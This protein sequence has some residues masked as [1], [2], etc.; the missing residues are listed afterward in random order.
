MINFLHVVCDTAKVRFFKQI[1]TACSIVLAL[2]QL[3]AIL[4]KYDFSSK[5]QQA[6]GQIIEGISCLRYCKSTI[7]Q[8]NHNHDPRE[9]LKKQLF[10]ILQKYDF[11]SK[12]QLTI[13]FAFLLL[14]CLRYCK[15]TIFQANH[16]HYEVIEQDGNVVCDTAKVR[17]FKQITTYLVMW[18]YGHQLFAIL[19]KYDFSSKSQPRSS[20]SAL[21]TVVCDTA[22]VRFFKQITTSTIGLCIGSMLFAILQKYDFSSKSQ[23]RSRRTSILL[24]CLR[25]CKSTIFQANHNAS[26]KDLVLFLVVCDTAKVR[27]FKQITTEVGIFE[28][29]CELFAILQKYDFSSK[30]QQT[31]AD[32]AD[33]SV[34]CDTAKVRFFKQITTNGEPLS[35]WSMLFAIL[36]KYDFSS[37]SQPTCDRYS[38][39]PVVCDTAKVRFFK[40]I[41]TAVLLPNF[42]A[43]CLRYCKST[44]FQANHN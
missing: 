4:Q 33:L 30:S 40:Q 3:F 23:R 36:Q 41:T 19:Q 28:I 17:F 2:L 37:K 22:K 5:S 31:S 43:C 29:V 21:A 10:A 14:S 24:S 9:F 20:A 15:S 25:Y 11:S 42:F 26:V 18:R 12:S 32:I 38:S 35:Y 34:V 39:T 16:N 44:I 13:F 1:T 7:F 6:I 8:A 27:F